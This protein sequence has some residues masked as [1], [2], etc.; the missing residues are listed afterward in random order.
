MINCDFGKIIEKSLNGDNPIF[1]DQLNE[2]GNDLL[3]FLADNN[4]SLNR[5]SGYWKNQSYIR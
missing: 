5:L 1:E 4:M 3:N 2:T